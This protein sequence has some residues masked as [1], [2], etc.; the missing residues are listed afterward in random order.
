MTLDATQVR[1]FETFG[2]LHLPG[3]MKKE[4][5]RITA[6]FESVWERSGRERTPGKRACLVPFIDRDAY[7]SGLLDDPRIKTIPSQLLGPDFNYCSSDGN[8]YAGDTTYHSNPFSGGL[9]ALKVAFYLDPVG[10]DSGCLRVFPGS[11]KFDD[12]YAKS[13]SSN[14]DSATE[15]WGHEQSELP[16]IPIPSEPGDVVVFMHGIKH[17]SFG[18][19]QGRRLF[20]MN[21]TEHCPEE[22]LPALRDHIGSMARFWNDNYYGEAMLATA[23]PERMRHLRQILDNQDHLPSLVARCRQEMSG[24]A[25]G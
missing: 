7:L 17:G 12:S 22:L 23:G 16:A 5:G 1:F 15:V 24:P 4:I 2:F 25:Q 14:I 6:A 19:A 20:V 3:L 11:H 21:F 18:G 13:L 9:A 8:L 10:A